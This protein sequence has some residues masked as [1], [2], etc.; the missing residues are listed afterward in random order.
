MVQHNKTKIHWYPVNYYIFKF[1]Y[2]LNV[3]RNYKNISL[4]QRIHIYYTYKIS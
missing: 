1:K 4:Q 3:K 2:T